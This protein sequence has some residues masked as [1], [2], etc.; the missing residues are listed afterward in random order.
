[1]RCMNMPGSASRDDQHAAH[2]ADHRQPQ[3]RAQ[4]RGSAT[5][6]PAA[7]APPVIRS[8]L[9]VCIAANS[10]TLLPPHACVRAVS[11]RVPEQRP[12]RLERPMRVYFE[13]GHRLPGS[14]RSL[15]QGHFLQLQRLQRFALARRQQLQ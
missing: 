13:R 11:A 12:Q 10:I 2:G 4:Q 9:S 5:A 14:R 1:M 15:G 3:Q 6:A 8:A 7:A